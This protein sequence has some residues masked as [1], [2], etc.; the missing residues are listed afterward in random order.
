MGQAGASSAPA[1]PNLPVWQNDAR[2]ETITSSGASAAGSLE[3]Q[4]KEILMIYCE[5]GVY[6]H[7]SPAPGTACTA[8]NGRFVKPLIGA[9]I[10]LLKGDVVTVI[11]A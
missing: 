9:D 5:T 4:S 3:A 11:D 2:S 10:N 8:T 1:G 7:V 6:C